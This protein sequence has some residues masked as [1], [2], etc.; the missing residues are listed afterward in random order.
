MENYLIGRF[1]RTKVNSSYSSSSEI[2]AGVPQGSILRP[3]LFN[4]FLKYVVNLHSLT[5]LWPGWNSKLTEPM[6]YTQKVWHLP[7]INQSPTNQVVAEA[8]RRSLQIA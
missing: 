5:P 1:Q 6:Q 2:M 8:L 4:I 3:L 7:Q